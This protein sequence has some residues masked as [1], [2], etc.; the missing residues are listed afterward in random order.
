MDIGSAA[1]GVVGFTAVREAYKRLSASNY[2]GEVALIT[3]AGTGIGREMA[4][5]LVS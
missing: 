2:G 3:G 5:I 4:L 1:V